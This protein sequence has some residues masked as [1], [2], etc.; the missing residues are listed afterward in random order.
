MALPRKPE[1]R[2][3][4]RPRLPIPYPSQLLA[5]E[6]AKTNGGPLERE[7]ERELEEKTLR[8]LRLP[9]A[10]YRQ[11]VTGHP[12]FLAN[13]SNSTNSSAVEG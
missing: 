12:G 4:F 8:V 7:R 13:N 11:G 1:N 6:L 10:S 5:Q 2:K 9:V 3:L